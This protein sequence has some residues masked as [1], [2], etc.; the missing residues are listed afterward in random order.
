MNSARVSARD[1]SSSARDEVK[2]SAR[3]NPPSSARESARG[4]ARLSARG[5][6]RGPESTSG[7]AADQ[8]EAF[9]TARD[10]MSTARMH[11][12]LAALTAE[13]VELLNKLNFI[14]STLEAEGRKKLKRSRGYAAPNHIG[15][16]TK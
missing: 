8:S 11:T 5:S 16:K 4:S 2:G 7:S 1:G 3:G 10:Y 12:A 13:R 9:E 15:E 14:D 6:V